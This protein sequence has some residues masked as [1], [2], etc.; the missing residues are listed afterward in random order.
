[1]NTVQNLEKM[2]SEA[3]KKNAQ[4]IGRVLTSLVKKKYPKA[5]DSISFD[6]LLEWGLWSSYI[7]MYCKYNRGTST[8]TFLVPK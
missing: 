4:R 7:R 5:K 6:D 3:S 8:C 1:M 2:C